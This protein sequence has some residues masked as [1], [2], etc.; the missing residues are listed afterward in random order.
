MSILCMTDRRGAVTDS[1]EYE[2][3]G[4]P[5]TVSGTSAQPL[6]FNAKLWIPD[7]EL[8][9]F[10]FRVYCPSTGRFLQPDPLSMF[11]LAPY[12]YAGN[13]PVTATDVLGL[14]EKQED[15]SLIFKDGA[16]FIEWSNRQFASLR[17]I[18]WITTPEKTI[19]VTH[20]FDLFGVPLDPA[21]GFR[22]VDVNATMGSVVG[23]ELPFTS[24]PFTNSPFV[25][26]HQVYFGP[27]A[28]GASGGP[29]APGASATNPNV[30]YGPVNPNASTTN[31]RVKVLGQAI[32]KTRTV[33]D[34]DWWAKFYAGVL[35]VVAGGTGGGVVPRLINFAG[36]SE[37][38][39]WEALNALGA[40][41]RIRIEYVLAKEL[42]EG[43]KD[44]PIED[45]PDT[46][47]KDLPPVS[48][49][50]INAVV[51]KV[52]LP[53][54]FEVIDVQPTDIESTAAPG[55]NQTYANEVPVLTVRIGYAD[56]P[57]EGV[58]RNAP[59]VT[60]LA[61]TL[62]NRTVTVFGPNIIRTS[63]NWTYLRVGDY[64]SRY[65]GN[66]IAHE[67]VC[68]FM[69]GLSNEVGHG[70][71]VLHE[72]KLLQRADFVG[73]YPPADVIIEDWLRQEAICGLLSLPAPT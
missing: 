1:Y 31:P 42:L 43:V 52:S 26:N 25:A 10:R 20:L 4:T 15:G 71:P 47:L 27:V 38:R 8:L 58:S 18:I 65:L 23:G 48:L 56:A 72:G 64:M 21:T 55:W 59:A 61:P 49:N 63:E 50:Q 36:L 45:T 3:W 51:S 62:A 22:D 37:E 2:T 19:R 53:G 16:E 40:P 69:A 11:N 12:R 70:L 57:P 7:A 33:A 73:D 32:K 14:Y 35:E 6:R 28:P 46:F 30:S 13:N 67:I 9:L 5:T 24:S 44:V 41:M 39:V 68:H 29:I 17:W 60:T 54:K 66:I 34:S